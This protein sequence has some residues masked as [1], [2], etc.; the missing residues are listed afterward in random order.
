MKRIAALLLCLAILVP[1]AAL[2]DDAFFQLFGALYSED[3]LGEPSF[4][5]KLDSSS[6]AC[7]LFIDF[8]KSTVSLI[9][10]SDDENT[11]GM[12]WDN[13]DATKLYAILAVFTDPER[14]KSLSD[15]DAN[16]F[17]VGITLNEGDDPV[18]ITNVDDAKTLNDMLINAMNGD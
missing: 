10:D 4:T 2:G 7:I 17:T 13:V 5:T 1:A 12:T 11:Y 3:V 16:D 8:S 6:K 18:F 9:G 15:A 14:F